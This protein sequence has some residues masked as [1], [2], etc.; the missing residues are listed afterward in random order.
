MMTQHAVALSQVN[1]KHKQ[2]MQDL[3]QEEDETTMKEIP[4]F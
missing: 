4:K 1:S 2:D 3:S